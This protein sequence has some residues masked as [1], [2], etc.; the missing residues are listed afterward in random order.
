MSTVFS[1]FGNKVSYKR[2]KQHTL[3]N[4]AGQLLHSLRKLQFAKALLYLPQTFSILMHL[5]LFS[6]NTF[7]G[8][9]WAFN[10]VVRNS[11]FFLLLLMNIG[12]HKMI[13]LNIAF[14][15]KSF[16][17]HFLRGQFFPLSSSL[18]MGHVQELNSI[19][20]RKTR[21]R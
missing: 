16:L 14:Q 15:I 21:G 4:F 5:T 20:L 2:R 18:M 7:Y 12:C 19:H 9:L 11:H 17:F 13:F 3:H 8:A 6:P 10:R 1:T